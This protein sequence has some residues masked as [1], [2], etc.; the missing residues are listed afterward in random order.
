MVEGEPNQEEEED[1][2]Q[3][4]E[5][6]KKKGEDEEDEDDDD[7]DVVGKPS[8]K[9][10]GRLKNNPEKSRIV[11]AGRNIESAVAGSEKAA[12]SN[13]WIWAKTKEL[14][15]AFL[16]STNPIRIVPFTIFRAIKGIFN[17]AIKAIEKRGKMSFKEGYG[18]GQD[19]FSTVL[20]KSNKK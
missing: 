6:E 18:I 10:S 13:H 9:V 11:D 19:V 8:N 3:P 2:E 7:E 17:F 15:G 4:V 14:G 5:E 16:D 20:K 12:S 1:I